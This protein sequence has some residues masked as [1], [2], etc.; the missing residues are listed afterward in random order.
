MS[1]MRATGMKSLTP[2][3]PCGSVGIGTRV[4]PAAGVAERTERVIISA[5]GQADL[6]EH[7]REHGAHPHRLLAIL[8]ALQ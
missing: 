2:F 8:R 7:G 6:A 5:A 3:L 1:V 4:E